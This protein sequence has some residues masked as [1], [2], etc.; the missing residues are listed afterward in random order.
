MA[1]NAKELSI[2]NRVWV[3]SKIEA[4]QLKSISKGATATKMK[5]GTVIT[6]G[7]VAKQYTSILTSRENITVPDAIVVREGDIRTVKFTEP[8]AM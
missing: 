5:M 4:D 7:G 3:Y 1:T 6:E 8:V 2:Y